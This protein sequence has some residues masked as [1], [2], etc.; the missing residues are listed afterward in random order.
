MPENNIHVHMCHQCGV[1]VVCTSVHAVDP[2][3]KFFRMEIPSKELSMSCGSCTNSNSGEKPD[4]N[5][6]AS[7]RYVGHLSF[8]CNR[9]IDVSAELTLMEFSFMSLPMLASA[10]QAEFPINTVITAVQ[11]KELMNSD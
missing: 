10:I 11:I 4:S 2:N 9:R 6:P 1:N 8:L 3:P 7:L 5:F